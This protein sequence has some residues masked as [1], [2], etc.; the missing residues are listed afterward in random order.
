MAETFQ[1]EIL[2]VLEKQER[3][4][5]EPERMGSTHKGNGHRVDTEDIDES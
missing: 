4:E 3:K 5:I 1:D 2:L